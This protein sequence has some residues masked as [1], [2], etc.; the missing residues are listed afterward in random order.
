MHGT[1]VDSLDDMHL[2]PLSW[3]EEAGDPV[4][5]GLEV[6]RSYLKENG[7]TTR[8]AKHA[9]VLGQLHLLCPCGPER[10]Q[11]HLVG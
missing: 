9:W 3:L 8:G 7:A 5:N 10:D 6:T 1:K 2:A 4:N 11:R